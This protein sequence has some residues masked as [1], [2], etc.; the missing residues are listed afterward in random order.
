MGMPFCTEC[1]LAARDIDNYCTGCGIPCNVQ[2]RAQN[3]KNNRYMESQARDLGSIQVDKTGYKEEMNQNL[4]TIP[5]KDLQSY[6]GNLPQ[7]GAVVHTG[8]YYKTVDNRKIINPRQLM[9]LPHNTVGS[10][11]KFILLIVYCV[12][13][14]IALAVVALIY[15]GRS[16]FPE[17]PEPFSISLSSFLIVI[18]MTFISA[19]P[20]MAAFYYFFKKDKDQGISFIDYHLKIWYRRALAKAFALGALIIIPVAFIE[21]VFAVGAVLF[22]VL[23]YL[24]GYG[25]MTGN[26]LFQLFIVVPLTVVLIATIEEGAKR[27]ALKWMIG[28]KTMFNSRLRIVL[29]SVAIAAS[30]SIIENVLYVFFAD[31]LT[32]AIVT[33]IAR[34]LT[35]GHII[36]GMIMGYYAA[37]MIHTDDKEERK[38]NNRKSWLY[39]I[40]AHGIFNFLAFSTDLITAY[41]WPDAV[42]SFVISVILVIVLSVSLI[43]CFFVLRPRIA[44]LNRRDL[45][46]AKMLEQEREEL[47]I[48]LRSDN[49][50]VNNMRTFI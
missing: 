48:E 13:I 35:P 20:A 41:F 25:D 5:S 46:E 49:R 45:E 37:K 28:K 17:D 26:L 16:V 42:I 22:L 1:G 31:N 34:G 40:L 7:T 9:G 38:R 27:I 3:L 33:A 24:L 15:L 39:P 36:F 12:Y 21:L 6:Q 4:A 19:I 43:L 8:D 10:Y 11:W 50:W 23:S 30:F 14:G 44:L 29:F 18:I 2:K 32:S 47:A